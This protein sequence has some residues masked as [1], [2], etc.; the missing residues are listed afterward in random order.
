MPEPSKPSI[1]IQMNQPPPI[2]HELLSEIQNAHLKPAPLFPRTLAFLADGILAALLAWLAVYS[3]IPVFVPEAFPVFKETLQSAFQDYRA[4]TLA[5]AAGDRLPAEI[6][7]RKLSEKLG[8]DAVLTVID[9][10]TITSTLVSF[11]YFVLSERLTR[12]ASL[13]KKMFRLRVISTLT[14]EPPNLLQTIS[15]SVWRACSVVP[16]NILIAL[17][18]AADAHVPFFSYR[19]R[20]WH[21]KLARTEVIDDK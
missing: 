11:A 14:G 2:P 10:I 16:A 21:D 6:F 4:A 8:S 7:A 20:A 12:G 15:R 5:M 17:I 19:R 9:F 3:L 1:G 18:V 13:G